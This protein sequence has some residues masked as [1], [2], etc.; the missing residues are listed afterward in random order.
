MEDNNSSKEATTTDRTDR[1]LHKWEEVDKVVEEAVN[2]SEIKE[3]AGNLCNKE[4]HQVKCLKQDTCS[5]LCLCSNN[6]IN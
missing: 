5:N 4:D 3:V 6:R 1:M 2:H